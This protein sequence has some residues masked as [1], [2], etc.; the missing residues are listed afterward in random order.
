MWT[1]SASLQLSTEKGLP[2]LNPSYGNASQRAK[3]S[4]GSF[5]LLEHADDVGR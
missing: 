3:P 4:G 2:G 1:V 5:D